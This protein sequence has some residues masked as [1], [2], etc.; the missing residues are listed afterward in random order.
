MPL[1][2]LLASH[3]SANG[4]NEVDIGLFFAEDDEAPAS[5]RDVLELPVMLE[6][7][8]AKL[9]S[10]F[11]KHSQTTLVCNSSNCPPATRHGCCRRPLLPVVVCIAYVLARTIIEV[12]EIETEYA[13]LDCRQCTPRSTN[14][15]QNVRR[16]V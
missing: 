14:K 11:C 9:A 6:G 5:V 8:G 1:A 13:A 10:E 7:L 15:V 3:A 16:F 4:Q 12:E 2:L